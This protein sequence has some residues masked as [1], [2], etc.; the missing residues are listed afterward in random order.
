MLGQ[1]NLRRYYTDELRMQRI[2]GVVALEVE[3][4][5]DGSV[6]RVRV[7]E[8]PGFGLG[9]AAIRAI[10]ALRFRPAIDAQ[11][12][13]VRFLIPRFRMRFQLSDE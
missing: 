13:A 9:P 2:E 7:V 5:A 8:D 4:R 10:R 11:G 6:G 3:V 12:R 1:P